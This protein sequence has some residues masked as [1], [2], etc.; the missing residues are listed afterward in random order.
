VLK[1]I[2]FIPD[3]VIMNR[4]V[5]FL[6]SVMLFSCGG[7]KVEKPKHLLSEDEMS[8]IIFDMTML[9]AMKSLQSQ[10]L[11]YNNIKPKEYIFKKYKID[12]LTFAQNNAWYTSDLETYEKIQKKVTD[13]IKLERDKNAQKNDTSQKTPKRDVSKV[14]AK[15]DSLRQAA[16]DKARSAKIQK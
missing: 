13:R 16:L 8:N 1:E 14:H 15:R 6:V 10:V 2:D 3:K 12:S 9:Q 4:I 11:D 5:F 7:D